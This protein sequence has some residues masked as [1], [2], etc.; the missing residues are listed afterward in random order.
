MADSCFYDRH[1]E[2][3][4]ISPDLVIGSTKYLFE[5]KI[6]Q[7]VWIC[8]KSHEVLGDPAPVYKIFL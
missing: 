5:L 6:S 8:W 4:C 3:F 1:L 7:L 2:H